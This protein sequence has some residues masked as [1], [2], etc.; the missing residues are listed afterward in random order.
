MINKEDVLGIIARNNIKFVRLQ[1][2][3]ILGIVKNV[4]IPASHPSTGLPS[5]VLQEYR[6]QTW[7]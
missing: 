6:S 3:D 2:V 7:Y 4:A 1:F 5:R